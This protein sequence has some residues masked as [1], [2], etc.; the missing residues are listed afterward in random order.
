MNIFVTFAESHLRSPKD[1]SLSHLAI[2]LILRRLKDFAK[3]VHVRS[4]GKP[5]EG[6]ILYKM[7]ENHISGAN[8]AA[9]Y[10]SDTAAPNGPSVYSYLESDLQYLEYR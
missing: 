5:V 1:V 8:A 3:L 10:N 9:P 6:S 4:S 2:L 7:F